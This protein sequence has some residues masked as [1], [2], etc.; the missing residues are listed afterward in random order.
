MKKDFYKYGGEAIAILLKDYFH[1]ILQLEDI[2][3]EWNSSFLINI[4]KGRQDK[5]KLDNK[6]GMSLTSYIAKLFEKI[7][8]NGL[9]NTEAQTG[10]QPGKNTLTSL[11]ALTSVIQQRMTQNQ[12]TYFAFMNLEKTFDRVWSSAIFYLLWK[13]GI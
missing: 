6:R 9:N 5:Q 2:S 7:L 12:E 3:I 4:D 10:A 1:Q 8:I 13:R 11:L